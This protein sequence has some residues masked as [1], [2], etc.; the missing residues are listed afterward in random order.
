MLLFRWETE[1]T[2]CTGITAVTRQERRVF[3]NRGVMIAPWQPRMAAAR[4]AVERGAVGEAGPEF[5]IAGPCA[6]GARVR[7]LATREDAA[8][9]PVVYLDVEGAFRGELNPYD[10]P[11]LPRDT[12]VFAAAVAELLERAGASARQFA[13]GADWQTVPALALLRGRHHAVLTLHNEFDAWLAA[14]AA[15]HGGGL[16][17]AF[18]GR[19]TALRVGLKLADVATTVNRGYARGLRTETIHTQV[20]A[21]HLQDLAWRIVPVENANFHATRA[22]LVE[23]ERLIAKDPEAGLRALELSRLE[24]RGMLPEPLRSWVGDK[25]LV[26]AMGR[27]VAQ[28]LHEVVAEGVRRL[29][30]ERPGLPVFVV[31]ATVAG[32]AADRARLGRLEELAADFPGHVLATDG[33]LDYYDTLLRAADYNAMTSLYEP[34]GGAFEGAVVP[35]VRMIDG[36]AF[37]VNPF[38]A[39]GRAAQLAAAW[40]DPWDLPSGLG[41]REPASPTEV[42][43]L[44][45]ILTGEVGEDNATFRGM[46]GSFAEALGA[47]V[48]L[49]LHRPRDY[50]RLVRG[51]LHAQRGRDWLVHLGG[52]LALVEEARLRRPL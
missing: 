29:L 3:G 11:D 5:A 4:A 9:M 21:R 37:Q 36:L 30:R 16:F 38:E 13:W 51:A 10:T 8:M 25:V 19:E 43:D 6:R 15:E 23:L 28:K 32:E 17:A 52:I 42:A 22:A 48:D 2:P 31:L 12:L 20:M 24:A 34:H 1:H 46:V 39:A 41:F 49:R 35:I 18:R 7:V 26:V 33:R 50:A 44:T 45:A 40:H 47:A 14:E 27:R